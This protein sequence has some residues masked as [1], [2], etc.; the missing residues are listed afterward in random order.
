MRRCSAGELSLASGDGACLAVLTQVVRSPPVRDVRGP[1]GAM[2]DRVASLDV[3]TIVEPPWLWEHAC[4]IL[5][6]HSEVIHK[7]DRG[8]HVQGQASLLLDKAIGYMYV[9]CT[10]VN[11]SY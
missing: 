8:V 6:S 4:I 11:G 1:Y 2:V 10:V 3:L 9:K 7:G 5:W